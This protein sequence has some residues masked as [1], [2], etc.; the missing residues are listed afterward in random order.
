MHII[1]PF[2][3]LFNCPY[4]RRNHYQALELY[5]S[6]GYWIT[7]VEAVLPGNDTVIAYQSPHHRHIKV[8]APDR[9]LLQFNLFNIGLACIDDDYVLLCD[10]DAILTRDMLKSA[11]VELRNGVDILQP[12]EYINSLSGNGDLWYD[13]IGGYASILKYGRYNEQ[14]G[15]A[16]GART[17]FLSGSGGLFD[18]LPYSGTD[19]L[20]YSAI[21]G[22][23]IPFTIGYDAVISYG[24]RI[25]GIGGFV[26]G[27]VTHAW[28]PRL[29]SS[30]WG[31]N[32]ALRQMGFKPEML[33]YTD[34]GVLCWKADYSHSYGKFISDKLTV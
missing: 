33:D 14:P 27:T 23:V 3:D 12:F 2:F 10:S 6:L 29:P 26:P 30:Y 18:R 28:H 4:R 7:T 22:H 8:T 31:V 17:A 20:I 11:E 16:L 13:D 9:L 1:I 5:D 25:N 34:E 21:F 24:N 32:L 15:I 19:T